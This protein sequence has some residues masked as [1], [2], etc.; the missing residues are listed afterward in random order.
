M[1]WL[2]YHHLYYFWLTVKEGGVTAAAAKLR[3]SQSTVSAQIQQLEAALGADLF[4]RSGRTLALTEA[5]RHVLRY[6][7]E[8]FTLG[9]ELVDGLQ[10]RSS[11]R[12]PRLLVG[13]SDALPKLI[14]YRLLEPALRLDEAPLLVCLEGDAEQ[15]LGRLAVHEVDLV[16]ADAPLTSALHVRAFNHL[17]GET[18]VAFFAAPPLARAL[19]RDFPRSLDGAPLLLPGGRSALRRSLEQWFDA[20]GLRPR[21][22]GE[23]EDSALLKAFGHAG[24]GVFAVPAAIA[25]EVER[26]YGVAEVGRVAELRERFYAITVERRIRHPAVMAVAQAARRLLE[27]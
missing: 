12:P 21:P 19:R 2:N 26:Q 10:G 9:R 15:L 27:S 7:E 6:A 23:F 8:I 3:L 1:D 22:V 13:V 11:G 16:L 5:G 14:V 17:L 24:H 18:E 4:R 25:A 20:R